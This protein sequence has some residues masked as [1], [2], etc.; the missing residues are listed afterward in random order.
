M[1]RNPA[2]EQFLTLVPEKTMRSIVDSL[3]SGEY[4][5]KEVESLV[6]LSEKFQETTFTFGDKQLDKL[7]G[8]LVASIETLNDFLSTHYAP[9]DPKAAMF[10]LYPKV[11][12]ADTIKTADGGE[13]SWQSLKLQGLELGREVKKD[14]FDL[15]ELYQRKERPDDRPRFKHKIP[16]G[17][18]WENFIFIISPNKNTLQVHVGQ[19]IETITYEDMGLKDARTGKPTLQWELLKLFAKHSGEIKAASADARDNYKK[20]K[21]LLSDKLQQ[22]FA[23]DFDP[24][25]PYDRAYRSKFRIFLESE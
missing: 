5:R 2:Y 12:H 16:A 24:F 17:M 7:A 25:E 21:Q 22:Y 18:R 15:V 10:Q 3:A 19:V 4:D 11:K 20:Q 13:D 9:H 23:I 1:E 8:K 14:Y 6:K